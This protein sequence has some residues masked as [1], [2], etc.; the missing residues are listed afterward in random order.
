MKPRILVHLYGKT[1]QSFEAARSGDGVPA[2]DWIASDL[3]LDAI[4]RAHNDGNRFDLLIIDIHSPLCWFCCEA[5]QLAEWKN[6]QIVF[7][8]RSKDLKLNLQ[9]AQYNC[10]AVLEMPSDEARLMPL[11]N[12]LLKNLVTPL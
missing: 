12:R 6:T 4:A 11:V 7:L 10:A 2:A 9:A 1:R 3:P 8:S 5:I